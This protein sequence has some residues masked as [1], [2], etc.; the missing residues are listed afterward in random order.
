LISDDMLI[1]FNNAGT[2]CKAYHLMPEAEFFE[3]DKL[4]E[5]GTFALQFI[6][7]VQTITTSLIGG[8][9]HS[10]EGMKHMTSGVRFCRGTTKAGDH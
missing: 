9:Y 4:S 8:V 2:T 1:K 5:G 10:T 7:G 3:E 6:F